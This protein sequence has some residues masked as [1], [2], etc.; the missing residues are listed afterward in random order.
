MKKILA[1]VLLGL[2]VPSFALTF[3]RASLSPSN[4]QGELFTG[5][6][7]TNAGLSQVTLIP[8]YYENA[9]PTA[10]WYRPSFAPLVVGGNS[11]NGSASAVLGAVADVGQQ[12]IA[13]VESGVGYFSPS[14]KASVASFFNCS[15]SSTACGA[16]SAGILGNLNIEEAGKFSTT[17]KELGRHP[18]GYFIGPVIRFGGGPSSNT[19]IESPLGPSG[20][21]GQ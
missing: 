11:G 6:M 15:A 1:A 13:A 8:I 3:Q 14:A 9:A 16:L 10:P 20:P 4:V 17:W 21:V 2:A 12:I 7:H 18:I 5:A 19:G